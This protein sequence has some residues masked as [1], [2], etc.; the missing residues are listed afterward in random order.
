MG[1][2]NQLNKRV[3][4]TDLGGVRTGIERITSDYFATGRQ[5]ALRSRTGQ[6]ADF[7][8]LGQ[9]LLD[10]WTAN[11]ASTTSDKY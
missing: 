7:M 2:T 3:R 10:Q 6:G 4:R 5:F 9:K 1:H 8:A 11:I